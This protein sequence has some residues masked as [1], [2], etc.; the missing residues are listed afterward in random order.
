MP[1]FPLSLIFNGNDPNQAGLLA[2]FDSAGSGVVYNPVRGDH[3]LAVYLRPVVESV[4][5]VRPYDDDW[6]NTDTFILAIGNPDQLPTGGTF[7]A[8]VFSAQ[9]LTSS[10]AGASEIT[11]STPHLLLTGDYVIINNHAGSTPSINGLHQITKTGADTFTIA[12]T[13]TVAGT[14]GRVY[15]ANGTTALAYNVS[16]A[17]F[18]AALTA[19]TAQLLS[20]ASTVTALDSGDWQIDGVTNGE[21]PELLI[22]TT[23]LIPNCVGAATQISEGDADTLA[24]QIVFLRRQLVAVAYPATPQTAAG[25]TVSTVQAQTASS[26][27]TL[28]VAMNAAGTYG[29][30][31]SVAVSY[32]GTATSGLIASATM[33]ATDFGLLLANNP[34]I[35]FNSPTG[36]TAN[37]TVSKSG[38]DFIVGFNLSLITIT[39]N[40]QAATTVVT[41]ATEHGFTT[42]DTVNI[43]NNNG[44]NA[45]ISG[46]HVVTVLSPT[47]FSI[48]IDCTT[49]GGTGGTCFNTSQP[50]ITV[51]NIDLLAPLGVSGTIDLNTINLYKEFYGSV[52]THLDF[53]ISVQRTRASGEVKTLLLMA[54]RI[55]RNI[56]DV[57]TLVALP[58]TAQLLTTITGV[59]ANA[60]LTGLIGGG[61]TNLDGVVTVDMPEN[62]AF[63]VADAQTMP[64]SIIGRI[65][66]SVAGS[67][68]ESAPNVI[69]PDDNAD[70]G[71]YWLETI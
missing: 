29:G 66:V 63:Y 52:A 43:P 38:G 53:E 22:G 17:V 51:A 49:A 23:S 39:S 65:F 41:T 69:V 7:S 48:P 25:V 1:Q 6:L 21:I 59:N 47:T 16:A 27:A 12:V 11:T 44:S 70:S 2:S 54:I 50:S 36:D 64:G 37:I 13:V 33:S 42:G 56:I 28:R 62:I 40:T 26:G 24:Q 61:S 3:V 58:L 35:I 68:A 55:S 31:F 4:S 15:L 8:G 45:D 10:V 20:I 46:D 30:T 60:D 32:L 14:G 5:G 9:I 71:I 18:Q 67:P 57:A 19:N 34:A